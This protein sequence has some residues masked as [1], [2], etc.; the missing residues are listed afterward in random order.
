MR[1][2]SLAAALLCPIPAAFG[3]S[4]I[5]ICDDLAYRHTPEYSQYCG[6][7]SPAPARGGGGGGG[8]TPS[9]QM[10][11][12]MGAIGAQLLQQ[13][14][15][16]ALYGDPAAKERQRQLQAQQA[17]Q[18]ARARAA[19]A[20]RAE[21]TKQRLLSEMQGVEPP[22]GG[23]G[24]QL[25]GTDAAAG[26]GGG[27]QLMQDGEATAHGPQK[28][29]NIGVSPERSGLLGGESA[30][31]PGAAAP[32]GGLRRGSADAATAP[33]PSGGAA[34]ASSSGPDDAAG[35]A[36]SRVRP[37]AEARVRP[38][39]EPPL[40]RI[41][42]ASAGGSSV[43]VPKESACA[44]AFSSCVDALE[45]HERALA[46]LR[47]AAQAYERLAESAPSRE[48]VKDAAIDKVKE[49][50]QELA[51]DG[52]KVE[53]PGKSDE[54]LYMYDVTDH[55]GHLLQLRADRVKFDALWKQ[56]QKVRDAGANYLPPLRSL[57]S[58]L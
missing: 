11:L 6:G 45:A 44:A 33:N 41:E 14:I 36:E 43:S 50:A 47:P 9:Q 12:Q 23:A 8:L 22:A 18:A 5:S 35:A 15:H 31:A 17:A 25:L 30:A 2:L 1:G 42:G 3:Q 57:L 39:V 53:L 28:V 56:D 40:R 55:A 21:A 24:L 26:G 38:P 20:A 48:S 19:A 4:S 52:F 7:G 10:T 51:D 37:P 27:L 54:G 34:R 46:E 58:E 16:N 32:S 29:V 13:G 49:R